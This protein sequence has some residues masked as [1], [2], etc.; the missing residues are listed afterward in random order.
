MD[1]PS[2]ITMAGHQIYSGLA[3]ARARY[4]DSKNASDVRQT[5]S[6]PHALVGRPRGICEGAS[7]KPDSDSLVGFSLRGSVMRHK[8]DTP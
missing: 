1:P 6:W 2:Q 4:C 7:R 3:S 5:R 8:S